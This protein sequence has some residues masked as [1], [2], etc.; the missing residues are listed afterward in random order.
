MFRPRSEPCTPPPC[1]PSRVKGP[2]LWH[3][4]TILHPEEH[5]GGEGG[6]QAGT[7]GARAA[8]RLDS[9]L[10]AHAGG[11]AR[12][13]RAHAAQE[14]IVAAA[15]VVYQGMLREPPAPGPQ[16]KGSGGARPKSAP[17]STAGEAVANPAK[18]AW[19][20]RALAVCVGG[21]RWGGQRWRRAGAGKGA[22]AW[23]APA[24][25]QP[26]GTGAMPLSSAAGAATAVAEL[27]RASHPRTSARRSAGGTP[28]MVL[29]SP[30]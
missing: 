17:A 18:N 7:P 5:D 1:P 8:A 3:Q 30:G 10:S 29:R 15:A 6:E 20:V 27:A 2:D 4:G 21:A 19:Q 22:G 24:A 13:A 9:Q 14:P 11:A 16:R 28:V 25:W 12:G 23:L 26:R